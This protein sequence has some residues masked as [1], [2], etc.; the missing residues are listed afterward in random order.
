MFSVCVCEFLDL[1]MLYIYVELSF[2]S[3]ICCL[4]V[5]LIACLL[6][7]SLYVFPLLKTLFSS[8]SIAS[9]HILDRNPFYRDSFLWSQQI[10]DSNS[11][12]W[13]FIL[14]S[15]FAQHIL[16]RFLI[17]WGWLLLNR[18]LTPPR[19]IEIPLHACHFSLF[20][21]GFVSFY[22]LVIHSILFH[23]IHAFICSLC[24]FD[25]L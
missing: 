12:H 17:H 22:Y 20:F 6:H 16:N 7:S 1:W 4:D 2:E 9:W 15:L 24:P 14:C 19:S 23:Y 8:S 10:L 25:H 18:L 11:T 3:L 13:E 21:T 5:W